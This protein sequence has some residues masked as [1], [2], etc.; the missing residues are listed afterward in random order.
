LELNVKERLLIAKGFHAGPFGPE[1][2][3]GKASEKKHCTHHKKKK[4]G[5]RGGV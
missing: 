1:G 5:F 4:K 2:W 3:K